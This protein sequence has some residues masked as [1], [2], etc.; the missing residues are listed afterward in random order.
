MVLYAKL[1][2]VKKA[3]RMWSKEA[4]GNIFTQKAI[5]ED[6]I[7]DKKAAFEIDPSPI[8]RA[9]LKKTETELKRYIKL[10]GEYWKQKVGMRWFS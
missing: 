7:K 6:I 10:G 1:S 9:E 5:L 8:N 2:R 4:F 3:L